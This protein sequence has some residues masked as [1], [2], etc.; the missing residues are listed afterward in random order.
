[1]RNL[2]IFIAKYHAFF[3]FIFLELACIYLI[4]QRDSYQKT[5]I[6]NSSNV[7]TG[8]SYTLYHDVTEY[9]YLK[10]VNDSLMAE[11]ARLRSQLPSA[12]TVDTV[13]AYR[14]EDTL[15]RQVYEY[16]PAK[17]INNSINEYNNYLTLNRGSK[18]GLS[19]GMGII[20]QQGIVGKI[21]NISDNYSVVMSAL[22][23]DSRISCQIKGKGARGT[24]MWLGNDP[25]VASLE[26][27]SQPVKMAVGDTVVT[28]GASTIFPENIMVGYIKS[29]DLKAGS[30]FYEIELELSTP[31]NSI[32]V[33]YVVNNLFK[34]EQLIL[35]EESKVD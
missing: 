28:T 22:H 20:H 30:N 14:I 21:I 2:F 24:L 10:D 31:F 16:Y 27:V 18:H 1:M 17:V 7:V 26:N 5:F 9:F 33:V 25:H 11:N 32:Q 19:K 34:T 6:I 23:K 3:L 35:E 15:Y 13:Q 12:F 4:I 29:F 8:K